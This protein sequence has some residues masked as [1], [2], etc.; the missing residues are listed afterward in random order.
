MI[1]NFEV[2]HG[3]FLGV[4]PAQVQINKRVMITVVLPKLH[5]HT[6]SQC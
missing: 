5:G 3:A 6:V 2:L 1:G 4:K